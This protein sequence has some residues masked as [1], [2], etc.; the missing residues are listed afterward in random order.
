[1]TELQLYK[2]IESNHIEHGTDGE[3]NWIFIPFLALEEFTGLLGYDFFSDVPPTCYL[4]EESICYEIDELA[5]HF[6]IDLNEIF[7]PIA[8]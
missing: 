5:E 6:D 1:M 4:K 7:E 2:F 8:V 3:K